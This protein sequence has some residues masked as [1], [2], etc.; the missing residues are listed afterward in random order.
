MTPMFKADHQTKT[1]HGDA[2]AHTPT[3]SARS[4]RGRARLRPLLEALEHRRLP[5]NFLVTS[6]ADSGPGTLRDA[7]GQANL[8]SSTSEIRFQD[9]LSEIALTSG[10]LSIDCNL[11]LIGPVGGITIER[12]QATGTPAFRIL[13]LSDQVVGPHSYQI[14]VRLEN[15]TITGGMTPDGQGGGGILDSGQDLTLLGSTVSGN[16][17]SS[18]GGGIRSNG[19]QASVTIQSSTI[20][21]N[22][23]ALDGGG[24]DPRQRSR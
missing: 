14:S 1:H 20:S 13:Q 4:Q 8:T 18:S 9:G 22:T 17:S 5:A 7:I 23:A 21:G 6:A 24:I 3:R 10:Q 16:S 15:M 12:S 11:T 19:L 2:C